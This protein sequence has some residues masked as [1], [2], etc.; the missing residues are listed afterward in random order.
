M[1]GRPGILLIHGFGGGPHELEPLSRRLAGLG[2][3]AVSITL[4]GHGGN[5]RALSAAVRRDWI[6]AAERELARLREDGP[7]VVIGFSMGGLIALRLYQS[8]PFDG[9]VTINTPV[10]YWNLPQILRNLVARPSVSLRYYLRE[11]VNK[12][13]RAL[14]E[15]QRLLRESRSL[16]ERV[17][18]PA[19]VCQT[20][21]DDTTQPRSADFLASRL[22]GLVKLRHYD[23]GG[24]NA[25]CSDSSEQIVTDIIQFV[26]DLWGEEP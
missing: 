20:L 22:A 13:V 8:R 16:P 7:A 5:R 12:P 21:D 6:E 26:N 4:K 14:V 9:L 3:R 10:W 18:C 11:S 2:Y 19:L 24:H 15:F 25:I 17:F 1:T 23:R